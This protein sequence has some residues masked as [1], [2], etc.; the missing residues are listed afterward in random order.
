MFG[1]L[2]NRESLRDLIV[3][4]GAHS[5]KYYHVGF[6]KNST[7]SNLSKANE[8]RDYRLF[9]EFAIIL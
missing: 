2:T 5:S 4:I 6:D 1:Q 8:N 7:K 3:S 9:E